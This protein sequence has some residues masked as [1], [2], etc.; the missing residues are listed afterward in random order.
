MIEYLSGVNIGKITVNYESDYDPSKEIKDQ[1]VNPVSINLPISAYNGRHYDINLSFTHRLNS[2]LSKNFICDS[3]SLQ[4]TCFGDDCSL[5]FPSGTM[6]TE[7]N[8]YKFT[9]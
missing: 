2:D 9:C 6:L 8:K 4:C 3:K 1:I 7:D 5:T